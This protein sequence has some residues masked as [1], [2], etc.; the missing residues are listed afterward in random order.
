MDA[1][2]L[3]GDPREDLGGAVERPLEV[4]QRGVAVERPESRRCLCAGRVLDERREQMFAGLVWPVMV[5][6]PAC[7]GEGAVGGEQAGAG[8]TLAQGADLVGPANTP[9]VSVSTEPGGG[10]GADPAGRQRVAGRGALEPR[11]TRAPRR[12]A[13]RQRAPPR[14]AVSTRCQRERGEGELIEG[15]VPRPSRE[16]GGAVPEGSDHVVGDPAPQRFASAQHPTQLG[17]RPQSLPLEALGRVPEMGEGKGAGEVH[18]RRHHRHPHL[19]LGRM[20]EGPLERGEL[21]G[22]GVVSPG[23]VDPGSE[24]PDVH[25]FGLD[26]S[27]RE[28]L[29]L[30]DP[31]LCLADPVLREQDVDAEFQDVRLEPGICPV[32]HSAARREQLVGGPAVAPQS[33]VGSRGDDVGHALEAAA[34]AA[35]RRGRGSPG[36]ADLLERSLDV[37][38]LEGGEGAEERPTRGGALWIVGGEGDWLEHDAEG[39]RLHLDRGERMEQVHVSCSLEHRRAEEFIRLRVRALAREGLRLVERGPNE[40]GEGDRIGNAGDEITDA[41]GEISQ[42]VAY[43]AEREGGFRVVAHGGIQ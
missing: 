13:R 43:A 23:R 35:M 36:A 8:G 16:R 42:G 25:S 27:L 30:A 21:E 24:R 18:G 26:V 6:A 10:P 9:D 37:V 31:V 3:A 12:R 11:P 1:A 19:R 38:V 40:L 5:L 2:H 32:V 4:A 22:P 20:H 39:V 29:E 17:Q 34:G 41:A 7:Q 14:S 33:G 28:S 15:R